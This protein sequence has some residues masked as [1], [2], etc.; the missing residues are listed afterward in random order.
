MNRAKKYEL[1]VHAIPKLSNILIP[2]EFPKKG[3]N[4]KQLPLRANLRW[5]ANPV[6]G[7]LSRE[8]GG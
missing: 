5:V 1:G 6:G 2:Y 8:M 7:W 4:L 3:L